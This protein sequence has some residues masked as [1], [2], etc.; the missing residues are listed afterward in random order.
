VTFLKRGRQ[1][2]IVEFGHPYNN[3]FCVEGLDDNT[4]EIKLSTP[5]HASFGP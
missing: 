1:W 3:L 2:L 4:C 5:S